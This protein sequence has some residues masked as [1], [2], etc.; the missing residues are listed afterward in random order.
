MPTYWQTIKGHM[1]FYEVPILILILSVVTLSLMCLGMSIPVILKLRS[2]HATRMQI[3]L[4]L[5]LLLCAIVHSSL[6]TTRLF[7]P[8]ICVRIASVI[9]SR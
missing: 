5:T 4:A 9:S 1:K 6:S 7:L 2:T 3:A 8:F